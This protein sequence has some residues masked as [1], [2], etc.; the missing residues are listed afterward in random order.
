MVLGVQS[1]GHSVVCEWGFRSSLSSASKNTTSESMSKPS[2]DS[3]ESVCQ[4]SAVETS[5]GSAGATWVAG[6]GVTVRVDRAM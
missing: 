1:W 5:S 2:V 6:A 3:E 4:S